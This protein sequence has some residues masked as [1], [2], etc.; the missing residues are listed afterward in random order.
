MNN[1]MKIIAFT[2][3]LMNS[4]E[5]DKSTHSIFA[6]APQEVKENESIVMLIEVNKDSRIEPKLNEFEKFFYISEV[7]G[8]QDQ[9]TNLRVWRLR[10]RMTGH[11]KIDSNFFD[12]NKDFAA[13][14]LRG[15][16]VNVLPLEH[17]SRKIEQTP[18]E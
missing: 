7:I 2:C 16:N 14:H 18:H 11:V 13:E 4:C 5:T 3:L 9:N 12:C 10:P 6:I 1:K 15:I 17:V 8:V